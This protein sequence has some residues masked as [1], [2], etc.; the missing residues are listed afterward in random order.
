MLKTALIGTGAIAREH[1]G[2]LAE[3]PN[4]EVAAVCDLSPARAEATAERFRIPRWF[5]DYRRMLAEARPDVVHVTTPPTSHFPIA[6]D[7]LDAGLHVL[8]EKP[9][10]VEYAEFLELRALAERKGVTLLENQ[11]LRF[12]SSVLRIRELL[13]QGELGTLHDVQVHVHLDLGGKGSR[14]AD[15]N[16]PHP[17]LSMRGGAIA[18]FLTHVGYLA[19]VFAGRPGEI[20]N[21][22]EKRRADSVLPVDEFRALMACERSLACV[23]VSASAQPSGCWVRVAGSRGHAEANLFEPPRLTVRRLRGGAPPVA[24]MLDGIAESSAVFRAATAGLWRKLGGTAAYDGLPLFVQKA[25]AAFEGT[26]PSPVPID[27]VDDVARMVAAFTD[28]ARSI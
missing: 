23:G 7:C 8:C 18:D 2:A 27:E 4:V 21:A 25:Y 5:T 26:A 13:D 12:H 1:L 3:M 15:P 14:F 10:T 11:N 9:I 24:T 6:R 22:W 19:Y 28:P 16:A 17:C 20:R